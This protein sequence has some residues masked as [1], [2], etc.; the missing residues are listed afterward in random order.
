M[1]HLF[2][3]ININ[4]QHWIF[5]VADM[6]RQ[7]IQMYDSFETVNPYNKQYMWALRRYLF[8]KKFNDVETEQCPDFEA[9]K[10]TWATQD[11]SN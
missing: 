6:E 10:R 7:S 2:V 9:W 5:L 11:R 4:N 8:D 1:K 3:P